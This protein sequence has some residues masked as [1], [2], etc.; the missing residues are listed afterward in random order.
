MPGG[1][2]THDAPIHAPPRHQ[3]PCPALP[4]VVA[5]LKTREAGTSPAAIEVLHDEKQ[6]APDILIAAEV[7]VHSYAKQYHV[8]PA[9]MREWCV[10][11]S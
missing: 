7:T 5:A 9:C 6:R 1:E 10:R 11:L 8:V 3:R 4:R 2:G